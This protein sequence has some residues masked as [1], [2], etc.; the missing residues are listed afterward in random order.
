MVEA[1]QFRSKVKHSYKSSLAKITTQS[2]KFKAQADACAGK[3][4]SEHL[5]A[6]EASNGSLV[7]PFG[8]PVPASPGSMSPKTAARLDKEQKAKIKKEKQDQVKSAKKEEADV[9]KASDLQAEEQWKASPPG[10]AQKWLDGVSKDITGLS[11]TKI[12]LEGSDLASGLKGEWMK[13]MQMHARNLI[14]TRTQMEGVRQGD[15]APSDMFSKAKTIV[16][17]FKKDQKDLNALLT[18]REKAKAKVS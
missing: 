6:N 4:L 15:A 18:M 13:V 17:D 14:S 12:R 5:M 16:D 8:P 1:K 10:L 3:T 2:V 9:K 11:N 7:A